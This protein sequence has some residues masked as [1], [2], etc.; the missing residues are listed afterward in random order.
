MNRRKIE[1]H[2]NPR[3]HPE[4]DG[5]DILD[6][7][8]PD[9]QQ[10]RFRVLKDALLDRWGAAGARAVR[11]LDVGCGLAELAPYLET[12]GVRVAYVGADVSRDVLREGARRHPGLQLVVADVFAALPFPPFSFDAVFASGVFNLDLGGGRE[13]VARCLPRLFGLTRGFL[14]ANFLHARA[15]PRHEHCVYYSPQEILA[16]LPDG[17]GSVHVMDGY[18]EKDFSLCFDSAP[19]DGMPGQP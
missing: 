8:S 1:Q 16:D 3:V 2:Y 18:L 4:R 11:L 13:A 15:V 7:S 6:W 9:E 14:L 19:A 10:I 12:Q 17:M 5:Y